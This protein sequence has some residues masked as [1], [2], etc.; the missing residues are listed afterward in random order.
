MKPDEILKAIEAHFPNELEARRRSNPDGWSFFARATGKRIIRAVA[1][2][3]DAV[4]KLKLAVSSRMKQNDIIE[5]FRG[6]ESEL[7]Q[8][9]RAEIRN[10]ETE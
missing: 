8:I 1:S 9:V 7:I 4:T 6:G 2:G 10:A 5:D 3:P